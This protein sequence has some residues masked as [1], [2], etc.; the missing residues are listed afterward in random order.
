MIGYDLEERDPSRDLMPIEGSETETPPILNIG[1]EDEDQ[2]QTPGEDQPPEEYDPFRPITVGPDPSWNPLELFPG[3]QD[4]TIE[5]ATPPPSWEQ[6]P[7]YTPINIITPTPSPDILGPVDVGP[8]TGTD[9]GSGGGTGG[10]GTG[11]GGTGGGT[12]GGGTGGG[13]TTTPPPPFVPN[14]WVPYTMDFGLIL[15]ALRDFWQTILRGYFPPQEAQQGPSGLPAWLL[16]RMENRI[17]FPT[18]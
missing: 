5:P 10:G 3:L 9:P 13:T 8:D 7:I 14:P 17:F 2:D 1:D 16:R 11:G 4:I 15:Q 12:G 18:L 6:F